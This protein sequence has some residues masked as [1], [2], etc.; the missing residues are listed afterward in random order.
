MN[1]LKAIVIVGVFAIGW[2]IAEMLS[3][4]AISLILGCLIGAA[5]C[6]PVVFVLM[7]VYGKERNRSDR[8]EGI[9]YEQ[10]TNGRHPLAQQP[11]QIIVLGGGNHGYLPQN[12]QPALPGPVKT[13]QSREVIVDDDGAIDTEFRI[14]GDNGSQW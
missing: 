4:D 14:V 3:S 5:L 11:P 1:L 8:L 2:R 10:R 13:R 7:W 9:L 6:V 12:Q